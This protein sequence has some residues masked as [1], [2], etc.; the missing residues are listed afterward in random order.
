MNDSEIES[1]E[2]PKT[3]APILNYK[4]DENDVPIMEEEQVQIVK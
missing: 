3:I 4:F 2:W 1:M